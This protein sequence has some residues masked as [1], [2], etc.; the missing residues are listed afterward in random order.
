MSPN[1]RYPSQ[2]G[3]PGIYFGSLNSQQSSP[4]PQNRQ[5]DGGPQNFSRR[6]S[7]AAPNGNF[8][9]GMMLPGAMKAMPPQQQAKLIPSPGPTGGT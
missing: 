6:S 2:S 4:Q 7:A 9:G 5:Y 8:Q 1:Y 3:G